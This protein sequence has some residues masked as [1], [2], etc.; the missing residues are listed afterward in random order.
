MKR[1]RSCFLT[2][3][4]SSFVVLAVSS[5]VA[6]ACDTAASARPDSEC[7]VLDRQGA[8]GV[9]FQL[10]TADALRVS[11]RL[12]PELRLQLEKYS[13]MDAKHTEEVEALRGALAL[14]QAASDALKL[15]L[16]ASAKE[17][18]EAQETAAAAQQELDRWWRSPIIWLSVGALAGALAG[19][20]IVN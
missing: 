20:A 16:E 2:L 8:K 9:W 7:V 18:R 3:V 13:E 15:E 11:H 17:A 4:C 1:S 19:I 14:R 6:R 12:I 5:P 10:A